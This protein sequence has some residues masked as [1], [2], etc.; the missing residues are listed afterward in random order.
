M[1]LKKKRL[2]VESIN[3]MTMLDYGGMEIWDGADMALLRET[4]IELIDEEKCRSIGI[5]MR[6]VKYIPSG[7]FGMLH[8]YRMKSVMVRLFHPQVNVLNMLWFRQFFDEESEGCFALRKEPKS[9]PNAFAEPL[10]T[11]AAPW[12]DED[13]SH[14]S[15]PADVF[16]AA[17][18]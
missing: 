16:D 14:H 7:F 13:E 4:L 10:P 6:S 11:I 1:V 2:S 3:G 15:T 9:V 8:D 18:S 5:D 17:T 12:A